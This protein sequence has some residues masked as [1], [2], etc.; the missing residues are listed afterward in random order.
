MINT[1]TFEKNWLDSGAIVI[2][3]SKDY[4]PWWAWH[5][6][7][8]HANC[9]NRSYDASQRPLELVFYQVFNLSFSENKSGLSTY[10]NGLINVVAIS[11][12]SIVIGNIFVEKHDFLYDSF[13]LKMHGLQDNFDNVDLYGGDYTHSYSG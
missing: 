10:N 1:L 13:L 11:W 6:C 4:V 2:Y 8:D 3:L 12:V 9:N 5:Q 7:V